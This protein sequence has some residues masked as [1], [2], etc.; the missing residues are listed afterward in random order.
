MSLL[1]QWKVISIFEVAYYFLIIVASAYPFIKTAKSPV[2]KFKL[3]YA[4]FFLITFCK[5]VS[6]ALLVG[7]I[8][9]VNK[10]HDNGTGTINLNLLIASISLNSVS[11]GM[12]TL[13]NLFIVKYTEKLKVSADDFQE[14]PKA[15]YSFPLLKVFFPVDAIK[16]ARA[17]SHLLAFESLTQKVQIYAIIISVVGAAISNGTGPSTQKTA[18]SLLRAGALLY[19]ISN[20][21]NAG[22]IIL[23][24]RAATA[25]LQKNLLWFSLSVIPFLTVRIVYNICSAFTFKIDY[26]DGFNV[27]KFTFLFGD[28]KIFVGVS[29]V[30]ECVCILIFTVVC[31]V[32]LRQE[33]FFFLQRDKLDVET[34]SPD[35]Y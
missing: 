3:F 25:G 9:Q 20:F 26:N 13:M 18:R 35:Q 30:E 33:E 10:Y 29:F 28:W 22:F 23:K 15:G 31:W 21:F 2:S 16:H 17:G 19:L 1:Y 11:L 7:Y 4:R 34:S 14:K 8:E 24:L 6:G 32:V 27:N 12:L 5:L